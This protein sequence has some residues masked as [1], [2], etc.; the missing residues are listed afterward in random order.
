MPNQFD[1][2]LAELAACQAAEFG[3]ARTITIGEGEDAQTVA[4]VIETNNF[5]SAFP[6]IG[7]GETES[8]A[9]NVM[10]QK[11]LLTPKAGWENGEPP[12]NVTP[13][14]I[15]GINAFVLGVNQAN[16]ILYLVTGQPAGQ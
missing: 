9:Q 15:D 14:V 6:D 12:I 16:G 3:A 2:S 4:C 10:V 1:T 5:N 7:G 11:S 8:G 13:T